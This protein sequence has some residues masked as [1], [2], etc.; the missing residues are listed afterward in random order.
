[1]KANT[2]ANLCILHAAWMDFRT[3][4]CICSVFRKINQRSCH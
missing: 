1:M 3:G 2:T 4:R